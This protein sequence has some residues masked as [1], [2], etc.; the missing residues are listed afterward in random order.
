MKHDYVE[1]FKSRIGDLVYDHDLPTRPT[2]QLL[3]DEMDFQRATQSVFWVEA[4]YNAYLW[5]KNLR[6]P[7]G[8]WKLKLPKVC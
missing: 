7:P 6:F 4:A 8:A 1:T 2:A 3:F 5:R